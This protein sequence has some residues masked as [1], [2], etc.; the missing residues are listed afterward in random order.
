VIAQKQL[1]MKMTRTVKMTLAGIGV[2]FFLYGVFTSMKRNYIEF[3]VYF[4]NY[5]DI[6]NEIPAFL[7]RL[8]CPESMIVEDSRHI[9]AFIQDRSSS[10]S[11]QQVSLRGSGFDI[12][13]SEPI[14]VFIPEGKQVE[15]TWSIA[16]RRM[17]IQRLGIPVNPWDEYECFIF[18]HDASW[19]GFQTGRILSLLCL[20]VSYVVV[21]PWDGLRKIRF[22]KRFGLSLLPPAI[23]IAL[24]TWIIHPAIRPIYVFWISLFFVLPLLLIWHVTTWRSGSGIIRLKGKVFPLLVVITSLLYFL[25][26]LTQFPVVGPGHHMDSVSIP[27]ISSNIVLMLLI[28]CA[29]V[30]FLYPRLISTWE[31]AWDEISLPKKFVRVFI[32]LFAC[33][34]TFICFLMTLN[35]SLLVLFR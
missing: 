8:H 19:M 22:K 27:S 23:F 31:L 16:A 10:A 21:T 24:M 1:E 20:L 34:I 7:V 11:T 13:P 6:S 12:T 32:Y 33:P 26:L 25:G 3:T 29:M 14:E 9:T 5:W 4:L 18:V 35:E 28:P 30:I 15:L 17:G 2:L